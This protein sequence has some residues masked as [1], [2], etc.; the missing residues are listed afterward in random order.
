MNIEPFLI[1][2]ALVAISAALGLIQGWKVGYHYG[3]KDGFKLSQYFKP[4][5]KE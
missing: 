2:F 4:E 1:S 3:R 5:D